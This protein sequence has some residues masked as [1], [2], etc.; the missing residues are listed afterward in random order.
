L[1][2]LTRYGRREWAL[3]SVVLAAATGL[4]LW[5]FRPLAL[6]PAALW[7]WVLW[8]FRDPVR[9]SPD[10]PGLLLSPADG[11]VS[12]ITPLG[13][14]SPL[15]TDGLRVG[16]FMSVFDVHVNRSPCRAAVESV[17]HR[18]GTFLDARDALAR[19]RNESA[20]IRL[21]WAAPGGPAAVVVRQVAGLLARRIVTDLAVGQEL[22]AGQRIGM[23]K[24][25]SRVELLAPVDIVGQVCVQVG[26]KVRAGQ[27]VL[28]T[29][30]GV[31]YP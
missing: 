24:F 26:Q 11:R 14:D 15:Q 4:A 6:L 20:T 30:R 10:Q 31:A 28:M 27:T 12:D 7:A 9:P 23:I 8:F 3:A 2:R 18:K 22:S 29:A 17:V 25:G 5:R 1:L 21:R 16:I 13:P 19:E